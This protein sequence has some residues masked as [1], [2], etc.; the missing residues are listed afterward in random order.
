LRPPSSHGHRAKK[1]LEINR[2][3]DYKEN[4]EKLQKQHDENLEKLATDERH[5]LSGKFLAEWMAIRGICER[6]GA[7][8]DAGAVESD[9]LGSET[10]ARHPP[11]VRDRATGRR[12]RRFGHR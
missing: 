1:T 9:Y 2:G 7:V 3:S 8:A 11:R 4:L 5:R 10:S 6:S 12:I